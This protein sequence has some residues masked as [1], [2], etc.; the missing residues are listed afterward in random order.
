MT[1]VQTPPQETSGSAPRHF[2]PEEFR[3]SV[4]D[5]LEELRRRVIYGLVGFFVAAVV[6]LTFGDRVVTI[7]CRPL[8]QALQRSDVNPQLFTDQPTDAFMVYIKISLI[9]AAAIAS[10]WM[11][12]QIWQF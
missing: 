7:F 11:V 8:I 12:Y 5:H 6:C 9:C 3:M 1:S 2:D 4:G 10:P